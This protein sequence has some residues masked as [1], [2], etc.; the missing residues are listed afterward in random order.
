MVA[1]EE[2]ELC[3]TSKPWEVAREA[4]FDIM[5]T[6]GLQGTR[7]RASLYAFRFLVQVGAEGECL[8]G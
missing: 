7:V 3:Y 1:C 6:D 2:D 8:E 5:P 4:F